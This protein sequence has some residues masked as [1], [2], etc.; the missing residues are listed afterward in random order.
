MDEPRVMH[1][2][3][4][5]H[6]FNGSTGQWTACGLP[7]EPQ[8]KDAPD[9][10]MCAELWRQRLRAMARARTGVRVVQRGPAEWR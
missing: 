7:W 8:P 2:Q 10:P 6:Y 5:D 1:R 3:D 9:C 4:T